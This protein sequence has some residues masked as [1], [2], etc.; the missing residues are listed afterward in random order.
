MRR[1]D[2]RIVII[3]ALI[4]IIGLAYGLMRYLISLK[5]DPFMRP[6]A[7]A[8]RYVR[9]EPVDYGTVRTAVSER[10]R[11]RSVSEYDLV[12][13]ASGKILPGDVPLK[14]GAGFK[15]GDVLFT[16]YP[17]EAALSLRASKSQFLNT[18]ANLLPDISIDYPDHEADFHKFFSSI[19]LDKK[20]PP[21]PDI[22]DEKLKIFLASRNVLSEYLNI[23]KNEL[24][25]SRHTL[26]AAFN[27]TYT[28]VFQETGAYTNTGGRVAHAVRTDLLEVEVPLPRFDADWVKI[29]DQ[30]TVFSEHNSSEWRG[31]VVRKG[32][33][34]EENTQSVSV[35]VQLVNTEDN[36]L[37]VGE[38]LTA[39][40]EGMPVDNVME[41]PRNA[42]FN[43]N[44]VF[45]IVDGRL[46]KRIVNI[47][48]KDETTLLFNGLDEGE[49]LVLQPLINVMEGTLVTWDGD[50]SMNSQERGGRPGE[51]GTGQQ[52]GRER[53]P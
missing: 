13:E 22:R 11:V 18:L 31:R 26:R 43:T 42:V 12:A 25:L 20:L 24:Q 38:Y 52:A 40:F 36:P 19:S 41:I 15:K 32:Q 21:F 53:Q 5:E 6:P 48:K 45:V 17:D 46:Q 51:A 34:I 7:E 50:P 14:K 10:G 47:V 29:G 23:Q 30:A 3:A 9:A 27:G 8:T 33:I 44:E 4:F 2:R 35:F 37:L 49:N 39:V 28:D 16:I 1:I